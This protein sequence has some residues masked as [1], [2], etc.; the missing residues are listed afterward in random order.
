MNV[1]MLQF[2]QFLCTK[3]RQLPKDSAL[4]DSLRSYIPLC[5]EFIKAHANLSQNNWYLMPSVKNLYYYLSIWFSLWT[6]WL[7]HS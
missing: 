7:F 5:M 1:L 4:D 6:F 3:R 2:S